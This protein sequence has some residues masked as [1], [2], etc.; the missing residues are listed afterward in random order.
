MVRQ[1]GR[2][3]GIVATIGC[4]LLLLLTWRLLAATVCVNVAGLRLSRAVIGDAKASA[5]A[6]AEMWYDRALAIR[7]NDLRAQRALV[8]I[9]REREDSVA[10]LGLRREDIQA[11][12][13]P[14]ALFHLGMLDWATGDQEGAIAIWRSVPV[15]DYYFFGRGMLAYGAGDIEA[16][17]ADYATSLA[18]DSEP[19]L[20]K[21]TMYANLCQHHTQAGDA[22]LAV[23]WC[24]TCAEVE[25]KA[26]N[27][28]ALGR[29]H[30]MN[31]DLQ[32]AL[33]AYQMAVDRAPS[34]TTPLWELARVS[35]ALGDTSAA[36]CRYARIEALSADDAERQRARSALDA[37]DLDTSPK[38]EDQP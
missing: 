1:R 37:L 12:G 26:S 25:P 27:W 35:E 5:L 11:R 29:A 20:A 19:A 38:C 3:W 28:L 4:A 33:E 2:R 10:S 31:S 36:Y 16:A 23:A 30:E 32:N 34:S 8:R 17:L 21:R 7:P 22:D 13:D 14:L 18:I 15:S 9:A 24:R 6:A